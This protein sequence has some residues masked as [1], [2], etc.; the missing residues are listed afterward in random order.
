MVQ[1]GFVMAG[2]R[3]EMMWRKYVCVFVVSVWCMAAT[4]IVADTN[5]TTLRVGYIPLVSQLPVV[6][7]Y[8]EDRLNLNH[9][10]LK[11]DRYASYTSLTP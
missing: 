4:P 11:I 1:Q 8:A 9:T 2:K 5:E 3:M 6:L 7:V 10:R